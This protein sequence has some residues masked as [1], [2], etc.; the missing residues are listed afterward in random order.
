MP[1]NPSAYK[2]TTVNVKI[3]LHTLGMSKQGYEG[4]GSTDQ[5]G[6]CNKMYFLLSQHTTSIPFKNIRFTLRRGT[7][8][9]YMKLRMMCLVYSSTVLVQYYPEQYSNARAAHLSLFMFFRHIPVL[10]SLSPHNRQDYG[11]STDIVGWTM[12]KSFSIRLKKSVGV[13]ICADEGFS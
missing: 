3:T 8:Q 5:V 4:L 10:R 13:S 9:S 12:V 7:Q 11:R 6:R 1:T 2:T